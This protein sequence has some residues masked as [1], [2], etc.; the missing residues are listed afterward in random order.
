[1]PGSERYWDGKNVH[2]TNIDRYDRRSVEIAVTP[3]TA[4]RLSMHLDKLKALWGNHMPDVEELATA[5]SYVLVGDPASA[6][7]KRTMDASKGME[8]SGSDPRSYAEGEAETEIVPFPNPPRDGR[9]FIRPEDKH[10]PAEDAD[11]TQ[12]LPAYLGG[13]GYNSSGTTPGNIG[14]C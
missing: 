3:E 8:P 13:P 6:A 1:M 5:L 10:V 12:I 2:L 4:R 11:L 7:K 9:G 14:S